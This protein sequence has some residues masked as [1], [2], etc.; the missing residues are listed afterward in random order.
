MTHEE[1][2]ALHAIDNPHNWPTQDEEN[3]NYLNRCCIAECSK[4]YIGP[5]RSYICWKCKK[6]GDE[7]F[8]KLTPEQK[9]QRLVETVEYIKTLL[10]DGPKP[11]S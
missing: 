3:G 9:Q 7:A 5:K 10:K 8:N 11:L 2:R 6:E 4:Y 1:N